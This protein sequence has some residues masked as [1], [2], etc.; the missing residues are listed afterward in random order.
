MLKACFAA[1]KTL[2]GGFAKD[3]RSMPGPGSLLRGTG[4]C[5]FAMIFFVCL[6]GA[7]AAPAYPGIAKPEGRTCFVN[8]K[9]LKARLETIK[10]FAPGL[11]PPIAATSYKLAVIRIDFSDSTMTKTLAVTTTYFTSFKNFYLENSYNLLTVNPTVSDGGTGKQGAY[12]MPKTHAYYANGKNSKYTELYRDAIAV[13]TTS[14]FNFSTYDHVMIYH[15]GAGA[16]TTSSSNIWSQYNPTLNVIFIPETEGNGKDP[17]GT[18]C[19]EYGHQLGLPDL[20]NTATGATTVG[21]WSLMDAGGFAGSTPGANPSHLDAWSKQFLGFSS[22]ETAAFTYGLNKSLSQ[23]ETARAAF[24]KIPVMTG[25]VSGYNEYFFAEY[26][27]KAG[28]VFDAG[29]P[30]QGLLIWHVDDSVAS[31]P[32]VLAMNNVNAV[33]LRPGVGLV[34]ADTSK[35]SASSGDAGDPWSDTSLY[36]TFQSPMS[37][38]YSGNC[39]GIVISNISGAGS[40]NISFTLKDAF[41]N[42]AVRNN[43]QAGG[44]VITGGEKGYVNPALGE[45]VIIALRSV[46][47]GPVEI[48]IFSITGD[49]VFSKSLT[50]NVNQQDVVQWDCKNTFGD[51]VAS[52]IYLIYI[53]GGGL[54]VTKKVAIAR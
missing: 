48:K 17:L 11:A 19:H 28:A 8:E 42:P 9:A 21:Y 51:T 46:K 45:N 24:L 27:R 4:I 30:G 12:R 5:L 49:M 44:V 52:G 35:P 18:Y 54:D 13:A 3:L 1:G 2:T 43:T 33:S 53:G 7:S 36:T 14:G 26:R 20:Y 25:D 10:K 23:A 31:D 37:N 29:L 38:S 40:A 39:T 32:S 6:K 41:D 34:S 16:E 50:G 22:P 47:F 15:A